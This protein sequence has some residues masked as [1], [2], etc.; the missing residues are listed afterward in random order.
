MNQICLKCKVHHRAMGATKHNKKMI[1]D[2]A[3]SMCNCCKEDVI[4]KPYL[5]LKNS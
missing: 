5:K 4:N 3:K 1:Y 2:N